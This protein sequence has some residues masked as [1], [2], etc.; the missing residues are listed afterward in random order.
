M[1][2][3]ATDLGAWIRN[4][5]KE[6]RLTLD[7]LASLAGTGVRFLSELERGKETAELGKVIAV[8]AALDAQLAIDGGRPRVDCESHA[9][10]S[11]RSAPRADAAG[12]A[13]PEMTVA[14][15][16]NGGDAARLW[17]M[18]A[19]VVEIAQLGRCGTD[20]ERMAGTAPGRALERGFEVLGEAAR[21]VTPA[22]QAR[23]QR[24][25]W[26]D[27]VARR[28]RLV[29]DYECV[30]HEELWRAAQNEIP[31]LLPALRAALAAAAP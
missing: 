10:P 1:I 20:P 8:L 31:R 16:E 25:P 5:R 18:L 17:D 19:A 14:R 22:T 21:R 4:Q 9:A 7:Q 27:L 28:N 26:R 2:T 6:R 11:P 13:S 23:F 12:E 3:N 30:D 29:M 15:P 24:V